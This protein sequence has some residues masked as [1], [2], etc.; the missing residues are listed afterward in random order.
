MRAM[1]KFLLPHGLWLTACV[2]AWFGGGWQA[3]LRETSGESTRRTGPARTSPVSGAGAAG[4]VAG[5]AAAQP[6][7]AAAAVI[8]ESPEYAGKSLPEIMRMVLTEPNEA[9]REQKFMALLSRLTPADAPALQAIFVENDKLGRWFVPEYSAFTLR[10]GQVD[11]AA[12]A[13][14]ARTHYT[15]HWNEGH[16]QRILRGWAE[17][18]PQQAVDWINANESVPDWMS[19]AAMKG[20][21]EGYSLTD[22]R[23]AAKMLNEHLDDPAGREALEPLMDR[24]IQGEGLAS[25]EKWFDTLPET[26]AAA[27][28]KG[29]FFPKLLDRFLRGGDSTTE[30]A[31]QMVARHANEPWFSPNHTVEIASRYAK[32]DPVRAEAWA[33]ALPDGTAKSIALQ[34]VRRSIPG[35]IL[36]APN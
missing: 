4:N 15:T 23:G 10:W 34:L 29:N 20:L 18:A 19:R 30:M 7:E 17:T 5:A 1:K 14:Y 8:M 25:A 36:R 26:E 12:S 13:E 22:L 31:A 33:T 27:A 32:L 9:L 24:F 2:L 6:L 11:G 35:G 16:M 28:V 21:V 3:G